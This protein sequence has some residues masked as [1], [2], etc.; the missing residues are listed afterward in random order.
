[1]LILAGNIKIFTQMSSISEKGHAKNLA[2]AALLSSYIAQLSTIY[3]PSNPLLSPDS[4]Q[5]L[6]NQ[7]VLEQQAVYTALPPYT[8]AVDNR[9]AVFAPLSKKVT[10]LRK[11]YKA[12]SGVTPAQLEDFMT[13][14]RKLKGMRSTKPALPENQ[15]D[16][17]QQQ[18]SV[19][20]MSFDQRTASYTQLVEFIQSTPN[21]NPNETEFTV[22]TLFAERDAM[23]QST[24]AVVDTYIPLNMARTARNRSMY[25]AENNL[26]DTFNKAK[27]YLFTILDANTPLYKTISK[28]MF[29]KQ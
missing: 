14:A 16:N 10:K 1:M 28:I 6:Y 2:N 5:N 3:K 20:Q 8:L 11:V 21:Y 19:S 29:K 25:L 17:P 4:L 22:A 13:L 24:Q 27:D 15:G 7:S 18:A 26:V 12:I 9:E 23:L